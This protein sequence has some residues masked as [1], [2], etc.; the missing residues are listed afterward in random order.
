MEE[1]VSLVEQRNQ[2]ICSLD[3]DVLRCGG[4]G[5]QPQGFVFKPK[6]AALFFFLLTPIREREEDKLLKATLNSKGEKSHVT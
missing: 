6:N 1:L 5:Q 2:I 3:Q 4:R